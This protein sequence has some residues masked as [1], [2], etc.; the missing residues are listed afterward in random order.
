M[1]W[2]GNVRKAWFVLTLKLKGDGTENATPPN[3]S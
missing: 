1:G 2:F 3:M